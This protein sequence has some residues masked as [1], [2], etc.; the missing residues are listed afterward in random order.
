M[1]KITDIR[2][3]PSG[4]W[5]WKVDGKGFATNEAGSGIFEEDEYGF[6]SRQ[7]IGTCDF[8]GC[9]TISGMR[10]KLKTWFY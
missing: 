2:H 4:R 7:T 10:R 5:T 1:V 9:K 3:E 8:I 6:Y